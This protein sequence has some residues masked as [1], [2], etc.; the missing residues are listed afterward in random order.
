MRVKL[1]KYEYYNPY[2]CSY[3]EPETFYSFIAASLDWYEV[4][5]ELYE[6]LKS[7]VKVNKDYKLVVDCGPS[8]LDNLEQVIEQQ[9]E[10]ER[11]NLEAKKKAEELKK[12]KAKEK[13]KNSLAK[14]KALLAKLKKELGE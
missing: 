10:Q 9:K 11:K 3:C 13:E 12:K 7:F 1:L 6:Y 5:D 2:D 4:D 14:K 8:M